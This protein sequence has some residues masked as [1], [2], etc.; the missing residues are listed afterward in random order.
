MAS[1]VPLVLR[2]SRSVRR[3]AERTG[4][5]YSQH[6]HSHVTLVTHL[7]TKASAYN[8]NSLEPAHDTQI[9]NCFVKSFSHT[10]GVRTTSAVHFH[11]P[12]EA[13]LLTRTPIIL[14]ASITRWTYFKRSHATLYNFKIPICW[15]HYEQMLVSS[16]LCR[17][18]LKHKTSLLKKFCRS[19]SQTENPGR[20]QLWNVYI[21]IHHAEFSV[22]QW[23]LW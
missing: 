4:P 1:D 19:G 12:T 7:S 17:I 5:G 22:L 9:H 2:D 18:C 6:G 21:L 10:C 15:F 11:A 8:N 13:A 20:L 23:P 3:N 16:S 14:I